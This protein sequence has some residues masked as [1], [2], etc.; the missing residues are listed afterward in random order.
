[1]T[2]TSDGNQKTSRRTQSIVWYALTA[3]AIFAIISINT[4]KKIVGGSTDDGAVSMEHGLVGDMTPKKPKPIQQISILGE[5]NSGTRWLY[6]YE[7]FVL[8]AIICYVVTFQ[9][10][11][12]IPHLD[13]SHVG[14]CFNETL[15][16]S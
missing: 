7:F 6:M 16:V 3:L 2:G 14:E 1:M 13:Q 8:D 12:G 15:G 4:D 11:H 10:I 5:R 9:L